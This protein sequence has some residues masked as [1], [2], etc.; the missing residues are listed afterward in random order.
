M[1]NNRMYAKTE[2]NFEEILKCIASEQIK[3]E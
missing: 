1:T 3:L 2:M